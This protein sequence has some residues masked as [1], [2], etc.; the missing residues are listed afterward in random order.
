MAY[1]Q[2]RLHWRGRQA[3]LIPVLATIM[4]PYQVTI[5]PLY[6]LFARYG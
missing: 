6:V 4:L 1:A 2:S 5:V 3:T